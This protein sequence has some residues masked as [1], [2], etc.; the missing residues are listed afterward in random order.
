[1]WC[2]NLL[3]SESFP[4]FYTLARTKGAML[5][6]VCDNSKGNGVCNPRFARLFND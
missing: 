5:A 3:L 1:M 4:K 2:G 6:E